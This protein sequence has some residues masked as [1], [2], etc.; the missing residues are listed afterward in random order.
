MTNI[1]QI[2]TESLMLSLAAAAFFYGI[3]QIVILK[4]PISQLLFLGTIRGIETAIF[5][6]IVGTSSL[7]LEK[8]D[9]LPGLARGLIWSLAFGAIVLIISEILWIWGINPI[10][11]LRSK[12]PRKMPDL[13]LFYCVGGIIAPI[14]EEIFFRGIIYGFFRRW[15]IMVAL[16][17]STLIFFAAHP[18][19]N[20]FQLVGGILFALAYQ[21]EKKLM[22]PIVIHS[23]GNMAIFTV[24]LL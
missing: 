1:R 10:K 17:L 14:A 20:L 24:S 7:G 5:V 21:K 6:F 11:L 19:G 13:I 16:I 18:K 4:S 8:Q 15:G 22:T 23:L 2:G 3:E 12:I 9:I